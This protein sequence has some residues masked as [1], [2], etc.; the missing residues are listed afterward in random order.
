MAISAWP[1]DQPELDRWLGSG[2]V[3]TIFCYSPTMRDGH[4]AYQLRAERLLL[5]STTRR[6]LMRWDPAYLYVDGGEEFRR[7]HAAAYPDGDTPTVTLGSSVW[8]TEY[9]LRQGGSAYLPERLI[10]THLSSGELYLVPGAPVFTRSTYLV[11][12]DR[13]M[14][15]RPWMSDLVDAVLS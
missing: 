8:A 5:V 15:E 13:T 4:T 11:M 1:G 3:D 6:K 14:A 2:L 7:S 9:V 12:S 10:Q